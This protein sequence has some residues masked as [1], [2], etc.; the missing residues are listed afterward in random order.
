MA[1]YPRRGLHGQVVASLG[2]RIVAGE[3]APGAP[4]EVE[5]LEKEFDVSRT[6]VREALRVLAG[7]GLVDAR[8]KRGTFV[9]PRADWGLLDPDVLRW[10]FEHRA[11]AEFFDTLAEVRAI[12]EPAGARLAATRRSDADLAHMADALRDMAEEESGATVVE[13]DLRFHRALLYATNNELLQRMEVI[14]E[15]GLRAR[16]VLVHG[17]APWADSIPRHQ[18]VYDAVAAGDPE[19]ASAAMMRLLEQ[20]VE[21]LQSQLVRRRRAGNR[22]R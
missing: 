20:A 15:S 1:L 22:R 10:Q 18:A 13:A 5:A 8:P 6:V 12:I 21:D 3:L 11:D 7:K 17:T 19:A 2:Q 9:R 16:D 14:I 4:L